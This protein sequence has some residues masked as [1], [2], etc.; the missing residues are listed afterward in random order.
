MAIARTL[1]VLNCE[2][3]YTC[4]R[5]SAIVTECTSDESLSSAPPTVQG[6]QA[7]ASNVP[8]DLPL[9]LP[10]DFSIARKLT[11]SIQGLCNF[12]E[13][14][15]ALFPHSER[16]SYLRDECIPVHRAAATWPASGHQGAFNNAAC[17]G[18]SSL[19]PAIFLCDGTPS[20]VATV[21]TRDCQHTLTPSCV[22]QHT[23]SLTHSTY[24]PPT[25]PSALAGHRDRHV[26]NANRFWN[27]HA[28]SLG[29]R[30]TSTCTPCAGVTIRTQ[31]EHLHEHLHLTPRSRQPVWGRCGFGAD[32][33]AHRHRH[34]QNQPRAC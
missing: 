18:L 17:Q 22:H 15:F 29:R 12:L 30:W 7:Q 3:V 10:L 34:A 28:S 1:T 19:E 8:L 20:C 21:L 26:V 4:K 24:H 25:R 14:E 31:H 2:T 6:C 9:D 11:T 13:C 16:L 27:R 23:H 33:R 32:R 5:T